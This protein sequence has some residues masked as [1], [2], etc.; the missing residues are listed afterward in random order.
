MTTSGTTLF[1]PSLGEFV[2]AAFRRCGVHREQLTAQHMAD[3]RFEANLVMSDWTADGINLWQVDNAT[4]PLIESVGS[5][6]MPDDTVFLLDLFIRT[7]SGTS[8]TDRI[9][10]P[11]S[12]SDYVA[13]ASKNTE[14]APTS[15]WFDRKIDSNL[16]I[17]PVPDQSDTYTLHYYR[18]RQA[19]DS[20]LTNG[21]TIDVP[22]YYLDAFTW[23]LA[24]RLALI[25]A[26]ERFGQ[27]AQEAATSWARSLSVGTE[28]VPLS[29]QP[30]M[31][32]YFR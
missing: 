20:E 24:K 9:I 29:I 23:A 16:Y 32:G 18:M 22:W 25:Y 6:D 14:G 11:I 4:I 27:I 30:S 1:N 8:Q 10:Y 26:P 19:Y 2:I 15:W 13:L 7:G 28:N 31:R 21:T 5:Y 12:R 3:A 17:W